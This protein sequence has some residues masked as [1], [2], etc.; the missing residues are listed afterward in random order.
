MAR[1]DLNGQIS[2]LIKEN[3]RGQKEEN[4]ERS[5]YSFPRSGAALFDAIA[6]HDTFHSVSLINLRE[7]SAA[8]S[9]YVTTGEFSFRST[10]YSMVINCHRVEIEKKEKRKVAKIWSQLAG[11]SRFG[12]GRYKIPIGK[13]E[14]IEVHVE[15]GSVARR[16]ETRRFAGR[17]II[18]ERLNRD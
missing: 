2:T 15:L 4:T 12:K 11:M 5:F 18:T 8:C 10:L 6:S 1:R 14:L 17:N 9:R 7:I 16:D 13:Y 3:T